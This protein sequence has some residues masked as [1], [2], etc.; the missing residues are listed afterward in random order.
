M[1]L[2]VGLGEQVPVGVH[3]LDDGF[4]AEPGLD[5]ARVHA[6][7]DEAGGVGLRQVW[8]P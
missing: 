2:L 8:K 5:D 1:G 3:G 6:Y 7:G 4:A